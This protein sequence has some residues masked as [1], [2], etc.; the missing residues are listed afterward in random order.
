MEENEETGLT[1]S[2]G[3][4]LPLDE[5]KTSSPTRSPNV[6]NWKQSE[7]SGGHTFPFVSTACFL[8]R[9]VHLGLPSL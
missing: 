8:H 3:P 9:L 1:L 7:V 6:F 2:V 4:V 5:S